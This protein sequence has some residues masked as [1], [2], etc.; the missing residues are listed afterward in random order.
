MI[1]VQ[2]K[3][4]KEYDILIGRGILDNAGA[5]IKKA[6]GG[7]KAAVICDSNT[8]PLYG[9]T[10][11]DSL[12]SAGYEVCTY[13]F[14]AGEKSKT[15]RTYGEIL[16]FL[17]EN[18]LDRKDVVAAL[19][20]GV[21]GDMGGF[22]AATYMRGISYV[23]IPTTL[24]AAVDSSVGG[25]TA[26][27]L[28]AGKNL[29]GA[30][31]QPSLVLC[32]T[33]TLDTLPERELNSGFAEVIKYG[34]IED[35]D[36]LDAVM[37]LEASGFEEASMEHLIRRC[38]EIK[39]DV[40]EKDE[41][42][43]GYRKVLNFGHTIGHAIEKAADFRLLHGEAVAAGMMMMTRAAVK[44]GECD[45]DCPERLEEA[46]SKYHLPVD[47]RT[48]PLDAA[49]GMFSK[50]VLMNAIRSDKKAAGSGIDIVLP[51]EAGRCRI[52]KVSFEEMSDIL[53][54]ALA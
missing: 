9:K 32:D 22:A 28:P 51:L 3:A 54:L 19:G 37:D 23:Q 43:G 34:I 52:E 45:P 41:F 24:L 50:E 12:A 6:A 31:Y 38:V 8:F 7:A 1:T 11:A 29:A 44:R 40:V 20:G 27:D 25:K 46:L 4:S 13:A 14:E 10:V 2:V 33:G 39:R 21:A 48:L 35:K 47:T 16:G 26:V 18:R 49:D 5:Y 36:I 30:F 42:E 53:D 15:L 17:A